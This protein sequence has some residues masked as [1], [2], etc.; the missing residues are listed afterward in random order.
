MMPGVTPLWGI[1]VLD[2]SRVLAGPVCCQL[3]AELGADVVKVERPGQG[4]D[5][6]AWGPPYVPDG[7][8]SAYFASAN[9]G[10]RSI[11]VDLSQAGGIEVLEDL[12]RHA[13]ILVENFLPGA[14]AKY[15][16]TPERLAELNPL[17]VS[18]SIS[19][20]G[21]TGPL[22]DLP[23]YDLVIQATSG[24]MAIT[25]EPAGAPMKVGVAIAD[26]ITGLY[27]ASS[28]LSGLFA[29][30]AGRGGWAFDLSLFDCTL[31]SLVN[32]AQSTL[33]TGQRPRRYGNAHAQIVPYEVFATADGHLVLAVGND[34]QWRQFCQASGIA[35]LG[36]H[37]RFA[38]NP[39]RVQHRGEL[40]ALLQPVMTSRKTADWQRLLEPAGVP[41]AAVV[42]L[43]EALAEPLVAAR[44]MVVPVR[45]SA[46]R[47]YRVLGSPI[48]WHGESPRKVT[49]P[50]ALGEH[51]DEVLR[52]W[53][54][55]NDAR[56]RSLRQAGVVA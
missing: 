28:A 18:C 9:H 14:A 30:I 10:K 21:R 22:S 38:T 6:R 51:T 19:G 29:R 36:S 13:D 8:P 12:I 25:G 4:D 44:Q 54:A 1:K 48:H 40:I 43:D 15:G 11:A 52:E 39:L 55:Y 20:Y 47:A 46:G 35:E 56:V 53:L 45:D 31:A 2:L 33:V 34:G 17:L 37:E 16:L 50:P 49:A 27:A 3:L 26:V 23:G 42:A 41:H 24:L 5:T 32:V 7:G